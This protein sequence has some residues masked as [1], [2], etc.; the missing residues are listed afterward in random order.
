MSKNT[1]LPADSVCHSERVM[2]VCD[3]ADAPVTSVRASFMVG[4][5]ANA[6]MACHT[7]N[8]SK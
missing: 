8:K 7:E 5:T 2:S 4:E 1:F 3:N 6:L